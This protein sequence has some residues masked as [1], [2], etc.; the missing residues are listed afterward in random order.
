MTAVMRPARRPSGRETAAHL[1]RLI[2]EIRSHWLRVEILLRGYW[3]HCAPEVLD[4]CRVRG[5]EFILGMPTTSALRGHVATL[6]ASTTARAEAADCAAF[7]RFNEFY[8]GTG[9]RSRVERNIARAGGASAGRDKQ[10]EHRDQDQH[11]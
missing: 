8:D 5:V 3:H 6:E 9:S 10:T 4:L 2:R 1:R 11:P 7:G